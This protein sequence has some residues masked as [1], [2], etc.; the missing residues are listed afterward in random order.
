MDESYKPSLNYEFLIACTQR[1]QNLLNE[2]GK[3]DV[4]LRALYEILEPL[5]KKIYQK[6]LQDGM[7]ESFINGIISCAGYQI[8]DSG[9]DIY[10]PDLKI[11][12]SDFYWEVQGIGNHPE[13]KAGQY[14]RNSVKEEKYRKG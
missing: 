2:H 12:Y 9:L 7:D 3:D 13:R 11:L 5:F 10:Y 4:S 6:Q 14:S 1:L 8:S